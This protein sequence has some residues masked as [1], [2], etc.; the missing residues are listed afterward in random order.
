MPNDFARS[1][2]RVIDHARQKHDPQI[3]REGENQK[4]D[5]RAHLAHQ[6]QRLASRKIRKTAEQR[7]RKK[8]ARCIDGD[9]PTDRGGSRAEL[10]RV[11]RQQRNHDRQPEHIYGD[12]QKNG[13]QRRGSQLS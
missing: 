12:N 13:E 3:R 6:Q 2:G 9:Q 5:Q 1:S 11:K 8:L 10:F 7:P 4:S